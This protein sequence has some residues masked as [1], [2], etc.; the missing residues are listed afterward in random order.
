LTAKR[1]FARGIVA[2]PAAEF[3]G[4]GRRAGLAFSG[5][6]VS[7]AGHPYARAW[8]RRRSSTNGPELFVL[9]SSP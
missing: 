1:S 4:Q 7:P 3:P 2:D 5:R 8:W 9:G 6:T